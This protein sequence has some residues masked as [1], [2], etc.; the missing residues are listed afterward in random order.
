MNG[1]PM[2]TKIKAFLEWLEETDKTA[3]AVSTT[4]NG[5]FTVVVN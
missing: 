4:N 3:T 2:S 5:Q 1:M